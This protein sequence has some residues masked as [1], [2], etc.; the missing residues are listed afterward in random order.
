MF[1]EKGNTILIPSGG[2]HK[3]ENH[4][5]LLGKIQE[6]NKISGKDRDKTLSFQSLC[7]KLKGKNCIS[8]QNDQAF[9]LLY[10]M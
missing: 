8:S 6:K 3:H 4:V 9:S 1:W 5:S 7:K 2:Y 10:S